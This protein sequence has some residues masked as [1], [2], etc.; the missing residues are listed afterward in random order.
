MCR[1]VSCGHTCDPRDFVTDDNDNCIMECGCILVEFPRSRIYVPPKPIAI[2]LTCDDE[3]IP[4]EDIIEQYLPS[5]PRIVRINGRRFPEI[6]CR[7]LLSRPWAG[8]IAGFR[9]TPEVCAMLERVDFT[10][11]VHVDW[12]LW[13][14]VSGFFSCYCARCFETDHPQG[15]N[16]QQP[17]VA[18]SNITLQVPVE[19]GRYILAVDYLPKHILYNQY[20][21]VTA[22]TFAEQRISQVCW[23][24]DD[25]IVKVVDFSAYFS[26]ERNTFESDLSL[27]RVAPSAIPGLRV[28]EYPP[29]L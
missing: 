6:I 25:P 4:T 26:V 23:I 17:P 3:I 18:R 29:F 22:T 21:L 1:P 27:L 7:R 5:A 19:H 24:C 12:V 16:S 11:T 15:G 20:G 14:W 9:M 8:Y 2:D 10:I 13:E 28:D